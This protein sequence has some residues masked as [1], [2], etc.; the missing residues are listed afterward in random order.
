MISVVAG[1]RESTGNVQ[2][3]V[4]TATVVEGTFVDIFTSKTIFGKHVS[5]IAGAVVIGIN[6]VVAVLG[7]C[8]SAGAAVDNACESIGKNHSFGARADK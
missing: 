5:S 7:A 6:N 3:V 4:C 1:A 8:V 2:A